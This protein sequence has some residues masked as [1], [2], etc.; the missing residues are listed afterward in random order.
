MQIR[1]VTEALDLP[2][3]AGLALLSAP[4]ETL[5]HLL[6]EFE[7]PA[8]AADRAAAAAAAAPPREAVW[9]VDCTSGDF[10]GVARYFARCKRASWV[11]ADDLDDETARAA[12]CLILLGH[13]ADV[14]LDRVFRL[15]EQCPRT[16]VGVLAARSA[17]ELS[18]LVVKT[19]VYG[20]VTGGDDICLAPLLTGDQA[21]GS[22]PLTVYPD[23]V[24]A[25][26]TRLREPLRTLSIC[27]HGNEDYVIAGP[28]QRFCGRRQ[29]STAQEPTTT[30]LGVTGTAPACVADGTCAFEG[31]ELLRPQQIRA[32]AVLLNTCLSAKGSLSLFGGVNDFSVGQ[33]FLDG[34]AAALLASPLLKESTLGENLLFHTLVDSGATLGEC[35][36]A[37]N[38]HMRSTGID[39]PSVVLWGDPELRL[40][41]PRA[42]A[43]WPRLTAEP[44]ELGV[45]LRVPA[46]A[47]PAG[48]VELDA[49]QP[50]KLVPESVSGDVG[51]A[52]FWFRG[53]LPVGEGVLL[54]PLDP[55][56]R[57]RTEV[58][59]VLRAVEHATTTRSL[60]DAIRS[61]D[62]LRFLGVYADAHKGG[63]R[64]S[65]QSLPTLVRLEA[66]ARLDL[67]LFP[68]F[69][70]RRQPVRD[71]L[72]ESDSLVLN[73]LLKMTRRS[74]FHFVEGYRSI[75]EN[76]ARIADEPCPYC[77]E[78]VLRYECWSLHDPDM[79]RYLD[80]CPVCGANQDVDRPDVR[81]FVS[82]KTELL[83]HVDIPFS[84][85]LTNNS[86]QAID[87]V[88]GGEFTHGVLDGL[89]VSLSE[90]EVRARP[91]ETATVEGS[92]RMNSPGNR[93]T[94]RLRLYVVTGG[95]VLF[96][97]RS[98]GV[99][100]GSRP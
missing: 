44:D 14:G 100:L 90:S 97:G 22:M 63:L 75:I 60:A 13:E 8:L 88:I 48:F 78:V 85:E 47:R 54:L 91:G 6:A 70:K 43:D 20:Q 33:A 71:D 53:R 2:Q 32:R 87:G 39:A 65:A 26:V 62:R 7:E 89:E 28:Q 29:A 3:V 52:L 36:R 82:C 95:R 23:Q 59:I 99:P 24:P 9:V 77:G 25:P 51:D 50:A 61:V 46:G 10:E 74:E 72:R 4:S 21:I 41:P 35:A 16:D 57:A 80:S 19:L 83:S 81:L 40:A 86:P 73:R 98:F 5:R 56:H 15:M 79:R 49:D 27:A 76:E 31:D 67:G 12:D 94:K 1:T 84:L 96:A 58:S 55:G 11:R 45:R 17:A 93:H 34:W 92:F 37:L 42:S 66:E 68:R 64:G 38:E 18:F 69:D 30:H